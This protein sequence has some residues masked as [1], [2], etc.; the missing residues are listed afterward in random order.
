MTHNFQIDNI[1]ALSRNV[2]ADIFLM[3]NLFCPQMMLGPSHRMHDNSHH[4]STT[5]FDISFF[6]FSD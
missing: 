3:S 5:Y 4:Q 1:P 6:K 2:R